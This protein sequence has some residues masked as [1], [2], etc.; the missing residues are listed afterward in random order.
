MAAHVMHLR[1]SMR[2]PPRKGHLVGQGTLAKHREQ[3]ARLERLHGR[4]KLHFAT[5]VLEMTAN[6][7]PSVPDR[8]GPSW[9]KTAASPARHASTYQ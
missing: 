7:N 5:P 9:A 1:R 4:R 8:H 3:L 6:S 2:Q